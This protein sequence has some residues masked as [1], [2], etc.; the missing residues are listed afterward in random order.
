MDPARPQTRTGSKARMCSSDSA[1]SRPA[2]PVGAIPRRLRKRQPLDRWLLIEGSDRGA[3][4]ARNV[5]ARG[6]K[7]RFEMTPHAG[8]T[9]NDERSR[10]KNCSR[11]RRLSASFSIDALVA[12]RCGAAASPAPVRVGPAARATS[13][14]PPFPEF[15]GMSGVRRRRDGRPVAP[16]PR[17]AIAR[18]VEDVG[19]EASHQHDVEHA[20]VGDENV[21]RRL[22]HVPSRPHL[23]PIRI[24]KIVENSRVVS[25]LAAASARVHSTSITLRR[26]FSSATLAGV[27][28]RSRHGRDAVV[29]P[30]PEAL[31][32]SRAGVPR[33]R[34]GPSHALR[35]R[36]TWSSIKAFRDTAAARAL[37]GRRSAGSCDR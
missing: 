34:A 9:S 35:I 26:R 10:P 5:L 36:L 30:E 21:R 32:G 11:Y 8:M 19:L 1:K 24:L 27:F 18:A 14:P 6:Q 25:S 2:S 33:P 13:T 28:L 20:V 29:P 16:D 12:I 17:E 22:L 23:R 7:R 31:P 3:A 37:A 15:R 4:N